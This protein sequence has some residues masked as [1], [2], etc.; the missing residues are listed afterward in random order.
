MALVQF[1]MMPYLSWYVFFFFRL[2][3]TWFGRLEFLY[4]CLRCSVCLGQ[5]CHRCLVLWFLLLAVS[6]LFYGF[7]GCAVFE[8]SICLPA[9]VS[10]FSV[11]V[12]LPRFL[13]HHVHSCH[14]NCKEE[15]LT[16]RI[17]NSYKLSNTCAVLLL[18]FDRYLWK[19]NFSLTS[20]ISLFH[21]IFLTY[22]VVG[23]LEFVILWFRFLCN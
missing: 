10:L 8:F 6:S 9:L 16:V 5:E 12:S 18:K 1:R 19:A 21:S 20:N 23:Y 4:L 3:S 7:V 13:F 11:V 17:T 14:E 15:A 22:F 2:F